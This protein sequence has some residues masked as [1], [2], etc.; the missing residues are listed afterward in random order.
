M[1][2]MEKPD[3]IHFL[4]KKMSMTDVY[5]PAVI[6]KLL[7]HGG[8][9][10][11]KQLASV[12]AQYDHSVQEYYERIVM[13]W[14]KITL[15]KHGIINYETQGRMFSLCALPI[16]EP[17]HEEAVCICDQ[18]IQEWV[19]KKRQKDKSPE[20]GASI[21]YEILK[22][23]HGKC[24]LCG[25][26]SE[27]RPID[28]DHIVPRALANKNGKVQKNGKLI[29][30]N[31]RENLQALCFSCNRAKRDSDQT[32]F[33]RTAKLVRD[34]IPDIIRN[35]GRFPQVEQLTGQRLR[36]ALFDKLIEEHGEFITA[37]KNEQ[38]LEE[39]AD[40]IEVIFALADQYGSGRDAI[41]ALVAHK[42]QERGGF[43]E[44]ILY[45]GDA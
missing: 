40:M 10:T 36:A 37:S 44:G 43:Q 18:K 22:S 20:V 6:K 34:L 30:V 28:I 4:T 3:L 42:R 1:S 21:R 29:D 13:R 39:L 2:N 14:P 31:D 24:Q 11:K 32:D 8:K 35:E 16:D 5:Q 19:T 17:T 23:A 27:L 9:R 41:L 15:T 25:I 26:S 38:K 12:L 33:R 45:N 7:L